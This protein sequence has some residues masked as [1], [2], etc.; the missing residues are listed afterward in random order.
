MKNTKIKNNSIKK[1]SQKSIETRLNVPASFQKNSVTTAIMSTGMLALATTGIFAQEL[2]KV[3]SNNQVQN[4]AKLIQLQDKSSSIVS[5][6]PLHHQLSVQK[7]KLA[8]IGRI[9]L[10]EDPSL[11]QA[12]LTVGATDKV[13][14]N[15]ATQEIQEEVKFSVYSNYSAFI[16][17][18]AVFVYAPNDTDRIKPIATLPVEMKPLINQVELKWA[19]KELKG[20]RLRQNDRL[21]YVLRVYDA[22]GRWDETKPAFLNLMSAA[23]K[24]KSLVN[25]Q[26]VTDLN[27]QLKGKEA[28]LSLEEYW[29]RNSTFGQSSLAI[30][31]IPLVGSKVK[32]RGQSIKE[33]VQLTINE[34]VVPIDSQK[35]FLMEYLLPVGQFNFEVQSIAANDEKLNITETMQANVSGE[36]FVMVAMADI[37]YSK[38]TYT[39]QIEAVTPE[40]YKRFNSA[41]TEAR[42]AFYL[43]GKIKG[44]YLLTAQADTLE[45]EAKDLL[46]GFFKADRADLFRKIDPEAYYPIYGDDSITTRDVDTSGR[47]YIRLDWDKSSAIFGNIK[48]DFTNQNLSTYSRSLYGAKLQFRSLDTNQY[49]EAY[50]QGKAFIAEQQTTP[51]RTELLGT[52]GSL[53]YL[54]HTDIVS[55]TDQITLELRDK[56][57]SR[58]VN[59]YELK[60]GRDYQIDEFQGRIVLTRPLLQITK[61]NNP[62]QDMELDGLNNVLVARYEY[63]PK[64]FDPNNMSAG[65]EVKKWL[66]EKL[67]LGGNFVKENRAGQDYE[68]VGSNL[69][70]QAG[71]GT[72]VKVQAAQSKST[73]APQFFSADGGL[74]FEES[75]IVNQNLL[76]KGLAYS[77]EA[78]ANTQEL[79]LTKNPVKVAAWATQKDANFSSSHATSSGKE[80]VDIGVEV[81]GQL[82]QDW[83]LLGSAKRVQTTQKL[84]NTSNKVETLDK[85]SVSAVWNY[86]ANSSIV[87]ELEHVVLSNQASSNALSEKSEAGLVGVRVNRKVSAELDIFGSVQASFAE[88]NYASNDAFTVGAKYALSQDS[89]LSFEHAEGK[90]GSV[91]TASAEY[92]R[93]DTHSVYGSYVYSP[94][95]Y[96][97][98][99]PTDSL[100]ASRT[101]NQQQGWTVG[102]RLQLSEQ[103]RMNSETQILEDQNSKGLSN[104]IGLELA[105]KQ[106][107][108]FGTSFQKGSVKT[109]TGNSS[110]DISDSWNKFSSQQV[111][112]QSV[113]LTG[114]YTDEKA[115]W[116]SK[117]EQRQDK[118]ADQNASKTTQLLSTNRLSYK[119]SED[120]RFISKLNYSNSEKQVLQNNA[121]SQNA[122]QQLAELM[123]GNLGFAWSPIAQRWNVLAKYAY[124]YDLAPAGQ[125]SS[126]GS[127]YDQ[128]THILSAEGVYELN[129]NWELG[130]KVARRQTSIRMDRGQGEWFTNDAT[131]AAAQLRYKISGRFVT[132]KNAKPMDMDALTTGW[133]LMAEYRMLKTEKDGVKKGFLVGVEKEITKNIRLGVGYNFTDFSADL[134]QQSYKSKGY[135]INLV[136]HF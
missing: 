86:D 112:R 118:T 109:T 29:L 39:G 81:L 38:N 133:A 87:T 136:T 98:S 53:Y 20:L 4:E 96:N 94:S 50:T 5:Q 25:L 10:T 74:T 52:G 11:L 24:A 77:L 114:A 2:P 12:S 8:Q 51:G 13:A 33:N 37:N 129:K 14:F 126:N 61:D 34:Q 9:W 93:T 83:Q 82:S 101:F 116:S 72:W 107:W 55:G 16:K 135:F 36:Y 122:K 60:V 111:D 91:T 85:Q 105:P 62:I 113:S 117:L 120:W 66:N 30:Q 80:Q 49:G 125:M 67:A 3:N 123:D 131:Y 97:S 43:K 54:R 58:V 79:G 78:R 104:S 88:K 35:R 26:Q 19:G 47:L 41:Q 71:A 32:I 63:Y 42:L 57:S 132:R 75:S 40:D 95:T 90:R 103:L 119:V 128:K 48:T 76:S 100:I 69:T 115:E 68:L 130:G 7:S 106:N 27:T 70:Y 110:A 84:S 15:P 28:G 89:L 108:Q 124:L 23:D 127:E 56:F 102:Q 21:Q 134:T 31:N 121:N 22:N 17:K 18:A 46:K 6:A 99:S 44:K 65:F 73:I 1:T 64:Q 59:T 45:K 92:K